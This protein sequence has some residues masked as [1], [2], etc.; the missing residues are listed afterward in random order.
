[1]T[2]DSSVG[3]ERFSEEPL[4]KCSG[5]FPASFTPE[6]FFSGLAIDA[7]RLTPCVQAAAARYECGAN[8]PVGF[9]A[10]Y[11]RNGKIET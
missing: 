10:A 4:P 6:G 5:A 11:D 2:S 7:I 9:L 1:M 8:S 3:R